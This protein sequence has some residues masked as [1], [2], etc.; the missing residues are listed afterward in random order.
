MSDKKHRTFF[1]YYCK[2]ILV[3]VVALLPAAAA[4]AAAVGVAADLHFAAGRLD[5]VFGIGVVG[6]VQAAMTAAEGMRM[7]AMQGRTRV[8]KEQASHPRVQLSQ[9]QMRN[10]HYLWLLQHLILRDEHALRLISSRTRG[11]QHQT[12]VLT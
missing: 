11:P 3:V 12:Q 6:F 1:S 10:V 9:K 7:P 5:L 4:A 8:L 2:P